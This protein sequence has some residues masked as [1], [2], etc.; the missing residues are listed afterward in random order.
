MILVTFVFVQYIFLCFLWV[1][2]WYEFFSLGNV[3][4]TSCLFVL[5]L[6]LF[7]VCV[8]LV[9]QLWIF[10]QCISFAHV[11]FSELCKFSICDM[12][13]FC[14]LGKQIHD[15]HLVISSSLLLSTQIKPR[16]RHSCYQRGVGKKM[17]ESKI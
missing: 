2:C 10:I 6:L 12:D 13:I 7:S 9:V 17:Q 16:Y 14:S 3:K 15:L 4:F 5:F 8:S 1:E 11:Y